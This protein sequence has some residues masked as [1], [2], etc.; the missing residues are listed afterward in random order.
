MA[1]Y[2]RAVR[3]NHQNA[4]VM[5]LSLGMGE[6]TVQMALQSA[7]FLPRTCDPDAQVT[8]MLA[9]AIQ[10][11][12]NQMGAGI[13]VT[14]S[15][16]ER[17][18]AQIRRVSGPDWYNKTWIQLAGDVI[19]GVRAGASLKPPPPAATTGL[20]DDS[21]SVTPWLLG[22]GAGALLFYATRRRRRR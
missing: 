15:L 18:V 12:L 4:R 1:N 6:Y 14:G 19:E 21:P 20:G 3:G 5:L 7:F 11:G 13:P 16:D 22:L 8:I 10:N 17:T 2:K 9:T